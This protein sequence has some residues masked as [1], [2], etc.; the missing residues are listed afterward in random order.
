MGLF[1]ILH[2]M[3]RIRKKEKKKKRSMRE[4]L[5]PHQNIFNISLIIYVKFRKEIQG[6]KGI[7]EIS[8]LA[9]QC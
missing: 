5:L 3:G 9:L 1:V 6:S 4:L 7:R 8:L 2:D